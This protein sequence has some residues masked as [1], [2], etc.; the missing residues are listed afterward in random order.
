MKSHS[1][2]VTTQIS[3]Q[4]DNNLDY[5][6]QTFAPRHIIQVALNAV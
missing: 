1:R 2:N 6:K 5:Q 3:A 4:K